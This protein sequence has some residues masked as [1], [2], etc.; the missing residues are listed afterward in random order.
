MLVIFSETVSRQPERHAPVSAERAPPVLAWMDDLKVLSVVA[1]EPPG[2]KPLIA[3][4]KPFVS[5]EI[6]RHLRDDRWPVHVHRP[7]KELALEV[8]AVTGRLAQEL[9]R[10]PAEPDLARHL[11]VSAASLRQARLADVALRPSTLD[12][13]QSESGLSMADILGSEDPRIDQM[14]SMR[15]IATHW[16]ELPHREQKI[17]I[18]RFRSGMTQA[19][20]GKQL[21]IS[22]MHVSR[23]LAHALGYLRSRLAGPPGPADRR[24]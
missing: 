14:L 10:T 22:Q 3:Y 8:R 18:L 13:P 15:A 20:I 5:G 19:Q 4:A 24:G 6:K 1:S 2:S 9:G 12:E 7:A 21:G 23:L 17:L 11:G 16:G